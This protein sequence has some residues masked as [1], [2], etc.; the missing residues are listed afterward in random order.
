MQ[1]EFVAGVSH[2]LCT[3]LAVINSAAENL[4]DGVVDD[5]VQMRE[6]GG[7]IR[8]QGRRLERLVDQVL[9][10][11]A[12]KFGRSGYDL[13]SVEI[14]PLVALS[15]AAAEPMLREAGFAVEQ[16]IDENLPRVVAD[17]AAVGSCI[18][19]LV[20]N[21]VKYGGATR[22]IAVRARAAAAGK[23]S[24]V[25]ISIE[26]KGI[27]ISPS[28]AALVRRR[29]CSSLFTGCRQCGKGRFAAW[30]WGCIW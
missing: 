23:P 22:W 26:D 4:V 3:P 28:E 25:E 1:M 19:N 27:G 6:Y 20:T 7:M 16:E 5:P 9:L 8:D 2:E 17:P 10:F 24:G 12:G 15:L 21:A 29:L 18:D 13:R 11:A 14:G 30:D